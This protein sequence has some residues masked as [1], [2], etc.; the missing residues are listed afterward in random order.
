MTLPQ[1]SNIRRLE[2]SVDKAHSD[3]IS[4][5][6]QFMVHARRHIVDILT[7]G[8]ALPT[9]NDEDKHVM[10]EFDD[11]MIH[12]NRIDFY[13]LRNIVHDIVKLTSAE[14]NRHGLAPKL[15]QLCS[16]YQTQLP[17]TSERKKLNTEAMNLMQGVL[18]TQ[19]C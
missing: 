10:E 13:T 1:H 4:K 18:Q 11:I 8:D 19:T 17:K 2:T 16:K 12:I 9:S 7:N 14:T 3:F 5:M 15:R 6:Q